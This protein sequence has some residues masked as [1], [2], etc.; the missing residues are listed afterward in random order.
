MAAMGL[1]LNRAHG[2]LPQCALPQRA[3]TAL[4]LTL[5]ERP[6][7]AKGRDPQCRLAPSAPSPVCDRMY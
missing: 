6:M 5:W 1:P 7:A 3:P 2:A 4:V